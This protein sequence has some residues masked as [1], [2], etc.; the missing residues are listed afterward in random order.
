M[1]SQLWCTAS[2]LPPPDALMVATPSMVSDF[3]RPQNLRNVKIAITRGHA[4]CYLSSRSRCIATNS[5]DSPRNHCSRLRGP[6]FHHLRSS[7]LPLGPPLPPYPRSLIDPAPK[8]S[9]PSSKHQVSPF[10]ANASCRRPSPPWRRPR[11]PIYWSSPPTPASVVAVVEAAGPPPRY[12]FLPPHGG[13]PLIAQG[14]RIATWTALR[15][16]TL[17]DDCCS[18]NRGMHIG[19]GFSI[20]VGIGVNPDIPMP[21]VGEIVADIRYIYRHIPRD[22]GIDIGIDGD[23]PHAHFWTD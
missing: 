12:D 9:S 1:G 13:A 22:A 15:R 2:A 20:G 17:I 8:L 7:S 21:I 14:L 18:I 19:R 11:R 6:Y 10:T 4:V 16:S 5:S 3:V 23:I